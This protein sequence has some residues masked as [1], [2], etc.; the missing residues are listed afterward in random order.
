MDSAPHHSHKWNSLVG[1]LIIMVGSVSAAIGYTL[2][3]LESRQRANTLRIESLDRRV[4][5]LDDTVASVD[6]YNHR[7]S[8]LERDIA[9]GIARLRANEVI[10][11]D[12]K[13]DLAVLFDRQRPPPGP[14]GKQENIGKKGA[15]K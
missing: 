9:T 2:A 5:K 4:V 11:N 13:S 6:V 3:S 12:L 8:S 14:T 10:L 7:I 1:G 15:P